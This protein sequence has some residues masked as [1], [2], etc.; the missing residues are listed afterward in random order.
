MTLAH[1]DLQGA[2]EFGESAGMTLGATYALQ[3]RG[4]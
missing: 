4:A 2:L 3:I 1:W